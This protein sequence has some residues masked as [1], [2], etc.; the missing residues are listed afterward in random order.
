[1]KTKV[2]LI[3]PAYAT[4]VLETKNPRNRTVSEQTVNIYATDM[5]KGRWTL[6]HQGIAFD[7]DGNLIDGQHRLWA[8]VF[9]E[10]PVEMLVTREIPVQE[11]KNGIVLCAM[12]AIDRNRVR[13]TGQHM[14]LCHGIKQ[15]SRV[16]AACRGIAM[17]IHPSGAQNRLSMANSLFIY[18]QYGKDIEAIIH[19]V[20]SRQCLSYIV[21]PL[22]LYHHQHP[23]KALA[24]CEQVKTL[25]GLEEPIR[26]FMKY[27]ATSH[28]ASS[29]NKTA[30]IF[31]HCIEVYHKG[32]I[33][34]QVKDGNAGVEFLLDLSPSINKKIRESIRPV[35]VTLKRNLKGL[36]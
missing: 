28:I 24:I 22:A 35:A 14:Q 6:T 27:V 13:S 5:K 34:K 19:S 8:V 12:D 7:T 2:E 21:A 18:E 9:A 30:R 17:L 23:E 26:L 31:A 36:L 3:T 25:A 32:G 20:D 15:G 4:E 1:M 16:G 29:S 10:T 11:V 33:I